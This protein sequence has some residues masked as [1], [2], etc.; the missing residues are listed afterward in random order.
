MFAIKF[1]DA[2]SATEFK[3]KFKSG[4]TEMSALLSGDDTKAGEDDASKIADDLAKVVVKDV[5]EEE[6]TS[7]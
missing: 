3:D 5:K 7:A 4:Q 6:K 1:N 2:E